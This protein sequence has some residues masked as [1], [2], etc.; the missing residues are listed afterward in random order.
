MT[1]KLSDILTKEETDNLKKSI[2]NEA[3]KMAKE[4]VKKEETKKE[5]AAKEEGNG[6][7]LED[8]LDAVQSVSERV[9]ILEEKTGS[10]EKEDEAEEE[11]EK[12]DDD[13]DKDKEVDKDE[14]VEKDTSVTKLEKTV[15]TL[16]K[17]LDAQTK[18]L[19]S[20]STAQTP[21]PQAG[22]ADINKKY[23]EEGKMTM[24]K[25]EAGIKKSFLE[26]EQERVGEVI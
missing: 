23:G 22:E 16:K 9:T 4:E 10:A 18:I 20:L 26:L 13:E 1:E 12:S 15:D 14:G 25:L 11:S 24:E 2:E 6:A 17:S 21:R 3:D 5:E 19:K 8:V 7:T